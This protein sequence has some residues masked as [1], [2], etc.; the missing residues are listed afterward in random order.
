MYVCF[1]ICL[2]IVIMLVKS[3]FFL[4]K[5]ILNCYRNFYMQFKLVCD[6]ENNKIF[7]EM[8]QYIINIRKLG[9]MLIKF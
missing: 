4:F 2:K 5:N 3:I 8:V 1:K 6:G 7:Y 9:F